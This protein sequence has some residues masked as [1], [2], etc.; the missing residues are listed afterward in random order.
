MTYRATL[1]VDP[2]LTYPGEA[3]QRLLESVAVILPEDWPL[4]FPEG[5]TVSSLSR[6]AEYRAPSALYASMARAPVGT[7]KWVPSGTGGEE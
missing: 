1:K 3:V 7:G 2:R 6:E 4:K 5:I